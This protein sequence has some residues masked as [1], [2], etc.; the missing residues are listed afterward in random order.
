[1]LTLSFS[2]VGEIQ[3]FRKAEQNDVLEDTS[4]SLVSV[5]VSEYFFRRS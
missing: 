5:N 1:M 3:N 2:T 4:L